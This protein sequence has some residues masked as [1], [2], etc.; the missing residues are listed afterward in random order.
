MDRDESSVGRDGPRTRRAGGIPA[1][2]TRTAI[3]V[4]ATW[5]GVGRI[6]FAPGTF[7]TATVLPLYWLLR[8]EPMPLR[9]AMVALLVLLA[10]FSA[11]WVA[12]DQGQEDPQII[13]IDE[14]AGGLIALLL[15]DGASLP[16]Q[17]AVLALFRVLDIFKPWPVSL[18]LGQHKGFKI[19]YDD[20]VAGI[21]SGLIIGLVAR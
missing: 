8:F 5:F 18:E 13:V 2:L 20:V 6:K 15:V 10:I 4:A 16:W 19:V 21:F 1:A 3:Y 7:A 11:D 12:A 14:V 9:L 17:F